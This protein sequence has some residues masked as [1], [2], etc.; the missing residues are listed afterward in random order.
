MSF[1][2]LISS[3]LQ[4]N[5]PRSASDFAGIAGDGGVSP[6]LSISSVSGYTAI[7]DA[8]GGEG[9]AERTRIAQELHDTLLQGFLAV[10][11]Q[12]HAAVDQLPADC[13]DA[14]PRF[15]KALRLLDRVLEQARCAIQGLRSPT[16]HSV[17]LS[18][19][20]ADVPNDLD[21]PSA[22]GFR[23]VILG[24]ERELRAGLRDEVYRIGREA[25]INAYRHSH[26]TD[27][28]MEI[29]YRPTELRLTVRDNGCGID[30]H[31]L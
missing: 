17:S 16:R 30:P 2:S 7:C 13:A 21:L 28:E 11:M 19:A 24:R 29:E 15:S 18:E 5:A 12:L 10:S 20:F 6:L 31:S 3:Q 4:D 23:V 9:L 26:A 27:I 22:V 1:N 14:K 25:I 8:L